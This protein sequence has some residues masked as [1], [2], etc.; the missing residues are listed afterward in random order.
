MSKENSSDGLKLKFRKF[1]FKYLLKLRIRKLIARL[2][3]DETRIADYF[4]GKLMDENEIYEIQGFKLKKGRTT[5]LPILTGEVEPSQTTLMKKIVKP[6][7][8]VFDL[9]ANFGWFTLVLSKLVGN[10]GRVYSFEVDPYLVNIL[11]ENVE[12]NS[13]SNVSIEPVAVSNKT[14]TSQFSLNESYDTRNQLESITKS[15]QTIEVKTI[16]LDDFC[17]NEELDKIDLIKMDIEGSEL[18]ALQGMKKII[19]QNPSLK[20]IMEFNQNAL[21]SVGDS[22]ERMIDFLVNEGFTIEEIDENRSGKLHRIDKKGLL[23]K[24]VCNCYCYKA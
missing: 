5:R 7:M 23:K 17:I 18:K 11:K 8:T 19:Y 20:I 21:N 12:L 3:V 24:K 9:G 16:Y 15:A 10:S 2:P 1:I 4:V 13:L 14:G 22:P 6:G